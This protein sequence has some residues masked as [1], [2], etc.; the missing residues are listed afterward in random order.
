[1]AGRYAKAARN[2]AADAVAHAVA[3]LPPLERVFREVGTHVHDRP[4]V[5]AF[6]RRTRDTLTDLW[7]RR[8]TRFRPVT[9]GG[10]VVT[11]DVTEFTCHRLYFHGETYEPATITC[12]VEHLRPGQ[13]FVDVGANHGYF[14][15][16]AARLVGPTGRVFAFE[17]N[18][19]VFEQLSEH[20][21]RNR[22]TNVTTER[23]ALASRDGALELFVSA[24]AG[25]SGLS[26][27]TPGSHA[28]TSGSLDR[29]SRVQV[30]ATTF[31]RWRQE[32]GLDRIDLMKIDVEGAETLVLQG[33]TETLASAPPARIICESHGLGE[34][35]EDHA[36]RLLLA[37]GYEA[38]DL[39]ADESHRIALFTRRPARS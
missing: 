14:T 28:F 22:L 17:P 3:A 30:R 10:V 39:D 1:M 21:A 36:R 20:V 37:Q 29:D 15:V 19:P 2:V 5:E 23:T 18:P 32:R 6:H 12:L 4:L 7:K 33:M 26:S 27:I 11:M 8:G 31:D 9:V 24:C 16:V 35:G 38:A 34:T 25:N 13:T